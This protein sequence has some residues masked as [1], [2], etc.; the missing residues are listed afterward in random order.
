MKTSRLISGLVL[1]LSLSVAPAI[2]NEPTPVV[3]TKAEV[4]VVTDAA[5]EAKDAAAAAIEASKLAKDAAVAATAAAKDALAAAE[6]ANAAIGKLKVELDNFATSMKSSITN[7]AA[8]MAK[9]AKKL[10]A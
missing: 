10:K 5:M 1:A 6:S 9:I 4:S 2:A 8:T 3:A 7:L